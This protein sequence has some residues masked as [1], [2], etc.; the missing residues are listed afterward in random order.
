MNIKVL[1]FSVIFMGIL[2]ILGLIILTI[3]IYHKFN[4]LNNFKTSTISIR[5]LEG[6]KV[7]EFYINQENI[8]VRY[9]KNEEYIIYIYDIVTGEKLKKIELLK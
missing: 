1:K 8:I 7:E 3:G 4:N 6:Y 9:K 5:K 2:I